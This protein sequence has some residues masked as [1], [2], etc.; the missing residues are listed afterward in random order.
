MAR[1]LAIV[2]V[3]WLAWT[4]LEERSLLGLPFARM[5]GA[6]ETVRGYGRLVLTSLPV[7]VL[8]SVC[9]GP[10]VLLQYVARPA[11]RA[12]PTLLRYAAPALPIAIAFAYAA[13]LFYSLPTLVYQDQTP[14]EPDQGSDFSMSS[15]V[16]VGFRTLRMLAI[17]I[18]A[19]ACIEWALGRRAG[20]RSSTK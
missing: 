8:L 6:E 14:E 5:R 19:L 15:A 17:P 18:L 11:P 13:G 16:L 4:M 1:H 10:A 20:V 9:W 2:F 12:L 3:V 7:A